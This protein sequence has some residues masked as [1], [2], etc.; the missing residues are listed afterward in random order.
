MVGKVDVKEIYYHG[1][2]CEFVGMCFFPR[3]GGNRIRCNCYFFASG[4]QW[5]TCWGEYGFVIWE[6][7]KGIKWM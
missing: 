3:Y 7:E 5:T 1:K 6:D 4:L 2:G